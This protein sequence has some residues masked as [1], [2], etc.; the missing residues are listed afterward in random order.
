LSVKR[1]WRACGVIALFNQRVHK[2]GPAIAAAGIYAL[3]NHIDRLQE[4]HEKAALLDEGLREINGL[5]IESSAMQT[6]M[7]F[8][9][10][11]KAHSSR[12]QEYLKEEGVLVNG[13][14]RVRLVTHL[15]IDKDDIPTVIQ[16]FKKYY[17]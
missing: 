11:G 16:A 13:D 12:L 8:V 1:A 7:V 6:N 5:E 10:P 3:E 4:D 9:K 2:G 15:D 14:V 17:Y